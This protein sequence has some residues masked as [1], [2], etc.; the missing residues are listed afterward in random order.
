MI[1]ET[2]MYR[3]CRRKEETDG[4]DLCTLCRLM[5]CMRDLRSRLCY[6]VTSVCLSVC[7]LSSVTYVI[8]GASYQKTVRGSK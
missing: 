4:A 3:S 7:R 5:L 1:C 8:N 2:G 6:S